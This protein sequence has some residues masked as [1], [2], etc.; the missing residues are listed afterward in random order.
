[1]SGSDSLPAW[2]LSFCDTD[3][4]EGEQFVGACIVEDAPDM[5][6]AVERAWEL[7]LN[8]GGQVAGMP[9]SD[10]PKDQ[11]HRLVEDPEKAE[12]LADR[13]TTIRGV[14]VEP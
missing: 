5:V 13:V 7:G 9:L 4:P 6:R 8:P 3:K 1:M 10:W 2:W 11:A 14:G 12:A